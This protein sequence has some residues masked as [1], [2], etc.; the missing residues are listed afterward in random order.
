VQ[1]QFEWDPKKALS[2]LRKHGIG[3]EAAT[4]VF[5]DPYLLPEEDR[6]IDGEDRIQAI[7]VSG[8]QM[9]LLTIA[10]TVRYEDDKETVI[11]IISARKATK[12]ERRRYGA[13]FS[14]AP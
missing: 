3:F 7:G 1:Q 2:N 5:D 10:H 11:R 9:L 13:I 12:Q 14:D 4:V 8:K 6:D